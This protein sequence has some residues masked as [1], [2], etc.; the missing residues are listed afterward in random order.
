MNSTKPGRALIKRH[1]QNA[2]KVF[3]APTCTYVPETAEHNQLWTKLC[4]MIGERGAWYSTLKAACSGNKDYVA[5]LI[6][7]LGAL[8]C[9]KLEE[10][11]GRTGA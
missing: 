11:M 2:D 8:V 7:D 5:Y 4:V 6:G 3:V 10:R 1:I 9:S